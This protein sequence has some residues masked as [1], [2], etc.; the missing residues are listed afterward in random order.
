MSYFNI[1]NL[2]AG[3]GK[4]QVLKGITLEVFEGEIVCV[5]GANGAGKSTLL[6]AISGL[7]K[8]NKGSITLE[9]NE[10]VNR[11]T[12]EIVS[13]RI[14]HV[15]EGRQV[16]PEM[17]VKENLLMGGYIRKKDKDIQNDMEEIIELLPLLKKLLHKNAGLLSGGEQQMLAVARGLMAKPKI[18]LLDE[19][20]MGLAPVIVNQIASIIQEI[21]KKGTTILLV[22]QNV[23]LGL[24]IANR[25]YVLELGKVVL[26][27]KTEELAESDLIRKA[28]LA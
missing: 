13:N 7:V 26:E 15:P 16:F 9:G 25:A 2:E 8:V 12:N 20:S 14:I 4:L 10:I 18:L 3:Y 6:R 24:G 22:E 1:A 17:S 21:N 19:P 11:K 28:Y 5:L 23:N 27:G